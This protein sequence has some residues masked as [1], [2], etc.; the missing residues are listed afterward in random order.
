MTDGHAA[1]TEDP[2]PAL[3][4]HL[5]SEPIGMLGEIGNTL[6]MQPMFHFVGPEEARLW[7]FC[8][9]ESLFFRFIGLGVQGHYTTI[10]RNRDFYASLSG[11]L[12]ED[13]RRA[14]LNQLW[15]PTVAPWFD[16]DIDNPD[17][18]LVSMKLHSAAYWSCSGIPT[19]F[20]YSTD[21]SGS[22]RYGVHR[23]I[24]FPD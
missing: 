18:A 10:S 21:R 11:I 22:T 3:W 24:T 15:N 1:A 13:M 5:E 4:Q 9:R 6:P 23:T 20:E 7:F 8:S 19:G 2:H 12:T 14:V 17:L 16:N